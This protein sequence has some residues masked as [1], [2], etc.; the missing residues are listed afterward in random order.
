MNFGNIIGE[1][2]K[3]APVI[4]RLK[5]L[6]GDPAKALARVDEWEAK[7]RAKNDARLAKARDRDDT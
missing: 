4:E 7:E 1:L 5:N 3:W 2:A 6:F